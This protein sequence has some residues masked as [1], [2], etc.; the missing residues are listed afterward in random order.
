M[1]WLK[2]RKGQQAV[3]CFAFVAIPLLLLLTFTYFPFAEMV[4]FSFYKMKYTT[5]VDK[6]VFVGWKNYIDVFKRDDC[7]GALKL[8]VYYCI[9]AVIQL[10]IA[11]FLTT[12]IPGFLQDV[13]MHSFMILPKEEL[14]FLMELAGF[15]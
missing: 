10:V 7:F 3:I 6:R 8:S 11:L 14:L 9:G 12:H 5:P 1:K 15:W 2:S 13:L 4:K